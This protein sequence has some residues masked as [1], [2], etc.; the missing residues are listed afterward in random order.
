VLTLQLV[1]LRANGGKNRL[2]TLELGKDAAVESSANSTIDLNGGTFRVGTSTTQFSETLGTL[3]L[4]ASS[5]IDLGSWTGG[6]T[7]RQITFANSSAIT[8]SGTLTITNWQGVAL[9]SSDVAEIIF[10]T[11]GLTSTQLGQIYFANQNINGGTLIGG[12]LVPVPEPRVYAAAVALLAVVGWR[13][14]KRLL[15][16]LRR[17]R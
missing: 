16:L 11:G 7:P 3:T 5:T 15:G 8:W 10:G 14:R 12:E 9:Q 4:S 6:T 13:E 2:S 17:K 1:D